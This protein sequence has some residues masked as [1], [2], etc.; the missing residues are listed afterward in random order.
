MSLYGALKKR[1]CSGL[2]SWIVPAWSL[3]KEGVL[4]W[5]HGLSLRGALKT[6]WCSGLDL[7]IL[8]SWSLKNKKVFRFGLLDCFGVLF[9]IVPHRALKTRSCSEVDLWIVLPLHTT[10]IHN[11]G[12][13]SFSNLQDFFV[14]DLFLCT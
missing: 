4:D 8:P 14:Y 11:V 13:V 3:K 1:R 7:W 2:N 10:I 6:T 9:R 12:R 5:T